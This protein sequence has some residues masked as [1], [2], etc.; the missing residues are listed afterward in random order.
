MKKLFPLLMLCIVA[1][2]LQARGWNEQQY[3]QIEQSIRVPQ[4]ADRDCLIT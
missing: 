3:K 1:L 4:F 2:G